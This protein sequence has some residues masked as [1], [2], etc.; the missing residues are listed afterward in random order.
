MHDARINAGLG[1][2]LGKHRQGAGRIAGQD[3]HVR[4]GFVDHGNDL[5]HRV[6]D[7]NLRKFMR[8]G[9]GEFD[10]LPLRSGFNR[11]PTCPTGSRV[12]VD[13]DRLDPFA[14]PAEPENP[15]GGIAVRVS[16]QVDVVAGNLD[17]VG[18]AEHRNPGCC[19]NRADCGRRTSEHRSQNCRG[20]FID[21]QSG[22]LNR[23]FRGPGGR[24]HL[25]VDFGAPKLGG[26]QACPVHEAL[27]QF[28]VV[29]ILRVKGNQQCHGAGRDRGQ[30]DRLILCSRCLMLAG[31][32]E[33]GTRQGKCATNVT[34]SCFHDLLPVFGRIPSPQELNPNIPLPATSKSA[35]TPEPTP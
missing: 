2:E 15:L 12:G 21:R 8:N 35:P 7:A 22:R 20:T 4:F 30:G 27:G 33:Q 9:A 24:I 14:I 16:Q 31:G 3:E 11:L 1:H 19:R 28:G 25:D 18:K 6:H 34:I 13:D 29:F 23:S 32:N 17:S 10:S 5:R 26:G